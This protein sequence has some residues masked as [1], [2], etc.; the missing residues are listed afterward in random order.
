MAFPRSV[1]VVSLALHVV[2]GSHVLCQTPKVETNWQALQHVRRGIPTAQSHPGNVFLADQAVQIA[3]SE[4]CREAAKW[5]V[6][7]ETG[8]EVVCG[9]TQDHAVAQVRIGKLPVGW[10][11]I[12]WLDAGDRELAWTT[13]AVL[14]PLVEPTPQDSPICVDAAIAW[15]AKD[16]PVKQD[17]FSQLAALAGV[18]WVRDR[19]RWRDIQ[20]KQGELLVGTTYDSS[21]DIQNRHGL[22]VLQVFHDTPPWATS[23][24]QGT[25]RFPAD[26]RHVYDFAR[27]MSQRYRGRVQAWE[28]W[29]EANV[30]N[31]GGHTID[32][33]CSYQKAAYL[34]FK[35]GDPE[36]TV[37]WNATTGVPT[38]RHT[39][40][41]LLNEASSYFDTYNIHTYDWADEYERLWKP[42]RRASCGKPLWITES[43]RG[44]AIDANSPTRDLSAIG[45]VL[46]AQYVT[47]SY[48]QSLHAGARRHFHFILGQYGEGKTQFGLLRHDLTPR[49]GYVALAALGRLLAG[50]RCL[51]RYQ[52]PGRPDLHAYALRAR[53]NGTERDVLVLWIEKNADW[54]ARGKASLNWSLPSGLEIEQVYDYLGRRRRLGDPLELTSAPLLLVLPRGQ[55]SALPLT[56][57][58][59]S[60]RRTDVRSDVVLQCVL[61]RG[62]AMNI[63]RIP[64]AWEH[65][66]A[67][68]CH[69]QKQVRLFVYHF[70]HQAVRGIVRLERVPEGCQLQ[71]QEWQVELEPMQRKELTLNVTISKEQAG[72]ADEDWVTLRGDF[73]PDHQPIVAFRFTTK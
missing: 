11:R 30:A 10:Y 19:M 39:D 58:L 28:P 4:G 65:E 38:E 66:Y 45:Q 36:V 25:G 43:D 71:P 44:M 37:C 52:E 5:R 49:P 62:A 51:G 41:V 27:A 16:D 53:P 29:N 18:N 8:A 9:A 69:V 68:P 35:A 72:Q 61:P 32:E 42:A 31:F 64:W 14:A 55:C 54:P 46:K 56:R 34:G 17:Q 47:Q 15:F 26:L 21:A 22:K 6:T 3:V 12:A 59:E 24:R 1:L 48:V 7:N 23:E 63:K 67:F 70:G 2:M 50:A 13:A 60:P 40:G 57:P 33:I 73:G 20:P